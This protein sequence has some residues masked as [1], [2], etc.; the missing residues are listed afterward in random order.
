MQGRVGQALKAREERRRIVLPARM[1]CGSGWADACILNLSSRGL[2]VYSKAAAQP[3]AF[4]EIRR[5]G[6]LVIARVVWRKDGRMG[7]CSPDELPVHDIISSKTA[8][9]I[10]FR[11]TA[12]GFQVERRSR[13]RSAERSRTQGRAIEFLSLVFVGAVLA[14]T[15]FA[16]VQESLARPSAAVSQALATR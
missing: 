1:R 9:A 8:A 14:G 2:M 11:T 6:Q 15:V 5:G 4:V 10:A 16:C 12:T 3:G 13:L 7:L